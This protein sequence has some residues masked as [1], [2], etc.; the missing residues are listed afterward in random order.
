V[1]NFPRA[2]PDP[3]TLQILSCP[4]SGV[5]VV[6]T[7]EAAVAVVVRADPIIANIINRKK[8]FFIFDFPYQNEINSSIYK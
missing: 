6:V 3:A 2:T 1:N 7:V 4:S 5:G 8:A